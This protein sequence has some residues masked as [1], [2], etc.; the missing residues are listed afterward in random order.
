MKIIIIIIK[1]TVKRFKI[2][3]TGVVSKKDGGHLS[4]CVNSL[5]WIRSLAR[6]TNEEYHIPRMKYKIN[7]ATKVQFHMISFPINPRDW[8]W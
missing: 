8:N 5:W 1:P 3:P 7:E 6:R 2:R 4:T